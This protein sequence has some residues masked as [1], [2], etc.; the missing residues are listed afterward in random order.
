[1]QTLQVKWF[2][3]KGQRLPIGHPTQ[4]SSGAL[5][6]TETWAGVNPPY[7]LPNHNYGEENNMWWGKTPNSCRQASSVKKKKRKKQLDIFFSPLFPPQSSNLRTT[8]NTVR[9][10]IKSDELTDNVYL[11]Y[12]SGFES[13]TL[14]EIITCL[15][16]SHEHLYNGKID[17]KSI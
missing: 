5:R 10:L 3:S 7:Q 2:V 1:M 9:N 13:S 17:F 6:F 15:K 8:H 16:P 14:K 11:F 12:L 4:T